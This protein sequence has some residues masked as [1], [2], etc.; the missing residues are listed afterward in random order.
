MRSFGYCLA[1]LLLIAC[2]EG[3]P[4]QGTTDTDSGSDVT[5]APQDGGAD[6]PGRDTGSD[7]ADAAKDATGGD[8]GDAGVDAAKDAVAD[9]DPGDAA[10]GSLAINEVFVGDGGTGDPNRYVELRAPSGTPLAGLKLRLIK[11]DGSVAYTVDVS[12]GGATMP[13]KGLWVVGGGLVSG[14]DEAYTA[15]AW[16]LSSSGGA[17]QLVRV[18]DG[19][20]ELVDVMGYGPAPASAPATD[21]KATVEGSTAVPIPNL[22]GRSMGRRPAAADTNDN[23]A[24]F[25]TQAVSPGAANGACL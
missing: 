24:D 4:A 16:G 8:A 10:V 17:V 15:A 3:D 21:P 9:V 23:A 22:T 14:V 18:V 25:C 19:G 5:V 11:S 7:A 6:A 2:A 1:P 20:F 13:G 12:S